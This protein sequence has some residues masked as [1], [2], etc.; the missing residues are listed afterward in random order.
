MQNWEFSHNDCLLNDIKQVAPKAFGAT[1]LFLVDLILVS[2]A[3]YKPPHSSSSSSRALT[4]GNKFH[5]Y[6]Y[7]TTI[8]DGLCNIG[9][10]LL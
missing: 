5:I 10:F 1:C 8:E 6:Q 9:E 4:I 7:V 2:S 3:I